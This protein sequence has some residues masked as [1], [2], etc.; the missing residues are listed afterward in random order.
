MICFYNIITGEICKSLSRT[1]SYFLYESDWVKTGKFPYFDDITK[2]VKAHY[3]KMSESLDSSFERENV[4]ILKTENIESLPANPLIESF[5]FSVRKMVEI[6]HQMNIGNTI[7]E[8]K[9]VN[10]MAHRDIFIVQI[11]RS[12]PRDLLDL[13]MGSFGFDD[14]Y[15]QRYDV[16]RSSTKMKGKSN[17]KKHGKKKNAFSKLQNY[18]LV[19]IKSDG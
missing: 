8:W 19:I 14:S 13:F 2:R 1:L 16:R 15:I 7:F 11:S 12:S 9:C 3:N 4:F 17:H 6:V 10:K 18:E 5:I